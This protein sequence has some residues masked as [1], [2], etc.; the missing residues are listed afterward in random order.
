MV[1]LHFQNCYPSKQLYISTT[2][3]KSFYFQSTNLYYVWFVLFDEHQHFILKII[4]PLLAE[5]YYFL[6][7]FNMD[8]YSVFT[9][10]F[11]CIYIQCVW[12]KE[13]ED[14]VNS[15]LFIYFALICRLSCKLGGTFLS[16]LHVGLLTDRA[17]RFLC[18]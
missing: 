18:G 17:L 14:L 4:S 5:T 8:S 3:G 11:Q 9:V 2:M 1:S 10:S 12:P 15:M 13:L 6:S 7:N 16:H